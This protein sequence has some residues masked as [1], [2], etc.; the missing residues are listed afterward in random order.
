MSSRTDYALDLS[1]EAKDDIKTILRKTGEEW[2]ENKTRSTKTSSIPPFKTSFAIRPSAT[3]AADWPKPT[4]LFRR[5][6]CC[7]LPCGWQHGVRRSHSLREDEPREASIKGRL[8][9]G[10]VK[11]RNTL[12]LLFTRLSAAFA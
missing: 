6:A 10:P 1:D 5:F 3:P 9:G 4:I 8:S 11:T 2:G 7:L 12:R